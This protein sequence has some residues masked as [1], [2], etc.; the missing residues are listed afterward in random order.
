M[1]TLSCPY[2]F[3]SM[4]VVHCSSPNYHKFDFKFVKTIA[5]CTA[6][7]QGQI[8]VCFV[9]HVA[10]TAMRDAKNKFRWNFGLTGGAFFVL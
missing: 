2:L 3:P 5:T 8:L 7:V 9:L 6:T 1:S 10:R 4:T